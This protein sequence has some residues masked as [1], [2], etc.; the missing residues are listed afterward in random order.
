MF[1]KL[2]TTVATGTLLLISANSVTAAGIEDRPQYRPSTGL[3]INTGGGTGA[4]TDP[5]GNSRGTDLGSNF[6]QVTAP[7]QLNAVYQAGVSD[8]SIDTFNDYNIPGSPENTN[9]WAP[10]NRHTNFPDYEQYV[11]QID[12][13]G[14]LTT[15]NNHSVEPIDPS[16]QWTLAYRQ[17][18]DGYNHTILAGTIEGSGANSFLKISPDSKYRSFG[19]VVNPTETFNSNYI[20]SQVLGYA[21]ALDGNGVPTS[22]SLGATL[23]PEPTGLGVLALGGIA[24]LGRRGR[25]TQRVSA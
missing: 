20:S 6:Y 25:R 17:A 19:E 1:K 24:L 5:W 2:L 22:G 10:H 16:L 11:L 18:G 15:Y 21:I 7:F 12:L 4:A 13:A 8:S 3:S 23:V 14:G 9:Q